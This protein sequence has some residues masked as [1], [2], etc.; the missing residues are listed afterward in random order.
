MNSVTQAAK[1][2]TRGYKVNHF[3]RTTYSLRSLY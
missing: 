1:R 3:K 2:K